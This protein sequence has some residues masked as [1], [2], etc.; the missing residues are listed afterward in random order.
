MMRSVRVACPA[1]VLLLVLA[2]CGRVH[3]QPI[4]V[5]AGEDVSVL[6]DH[7]EQIGEEN[8]LIAT[9]NVE[10]SRGTARLT[11]DRVEINRATG[12][13][14]AT[15]RVVFY[16]GEDRLAGE[17]I[18]YNFRTGT[19]VVYRAEARTAPYYRLS[20]ERMER[21]GESVYRVHRGI[22]T[23]CEDDPPPWSFHFGGATADL[24]RFV[25]GTNASFWV[26]NVPLIPWI[27]FIAAAI[28]RERQTGFLFPK[29]GHSSTKGFGAEIP[30]YWAISDSQDLTFAPL[31]FDQRGLGFNLDYRYILSERQFGDLRTFYLHETTR[32]DDRGWG[33]FRHDWTISP[34]LTLRADVRGVTDDEVLRE[35]GDG[36]RT[37]S[38]QRVESNVFIAR[39][40]PTWNLVANAFWYQDLTVDAPIELHRLPS[41]TLTGVRQPVPW[42]P[43]VLWELGASAVRFARDVG[44]DGTR[45]DVNPR[46]SRPFSPGGLFTITP[47]VGARV[48]TYDRVVTG[49]HQRQDGIVIERTDEDL[50]V[51]RLFEAGTDLETTLTRVYRPGRFNLDALLHSIEPRVRYTWVTGSGV[52]RLPLWS[53]VDRLGDASRIEYSVTNRVRGRTIAPPG[54]EPV[55]LEILRLLLAHSLDL[56]NPSRRS[57]ELIGD[58]IVQPT[59][60]MAFR[61]SIIHDTHGAGVQL[62]TADVSVSSDRLTASLGTRYSDTQNVNFLQGVAAATITRNLAARLHTDWDLRTNTFVENRYALDLKFQ[63]YGV[64]IEYVHRSNEQGRTGENEIRF[65]VNL[66]G[67]GAPITTSL[68]LGS[69]TSGG[70]A[71]R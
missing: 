71:A 34:T 31:F 28:R 41:V 49:F 3:G 27:P 57:G 47:F 37:R 12:D 33:S 54:S 51:R 45:V 50:R 11:A 9:G 43:G 46:L 10:V 6:A 18:D 65:A 21:I 20:G 38:E 13:A 58:L 66:L 48:T 30:F 36:L 22:F 70:S 1:L 39:R 23:T 4:A 42:V 61:G 44:S 64:T 56:G 5:P 14:V 26:K 29:F 7:L 59:P 62:A 17:R 8:L 53:E 55:R 25:Y 67:I 52:D 40:W 60:R 35:Y 24:E 68:G 69:L 2:W 32:N 16:D 19:G 63:C 15:G